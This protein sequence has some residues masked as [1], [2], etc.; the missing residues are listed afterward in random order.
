MPNVTQYTVIYGNLDVWLLLQ[1][2]RLPRWRQAVLLAVIF[3]NK[4]YFL[5]HKIT[6]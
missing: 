3:H 5:T 2:R 6:S 4:S 1:G